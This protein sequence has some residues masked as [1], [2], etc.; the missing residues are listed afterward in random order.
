MEKDIK[1]L[2]VVKNMR[3][4][5]G[6]ASFIMNYYRELVKIKNVHIDFLVVSD[7][8]SIYYDEIRKNSNI[9]FMPSIR[10]P[11][12]VLRFLKN[13]FKLNKYNILHSNVFNSNV[14]I[15]YYAKK[16]KVPIRILHSHASQ[17]GDSLIKIIRN[18]VFL[19]A[20]LN[21]SNIFFACS[22][23]AGESIFKK[24]KYYCINNA[25]D[26]PMFYYNK[27]TRQQIR[28][29]LNVS[30]HT[31]V[32]GVVG[33]VT[34]QKNPDFIIEIAKRLKAKNFDFKIIWI[35]SG[36][37]SDYIDKRIANENLSNEIKML[38]SLN[39]SHLYY[40]AFDVFLMPSF[41]EGLPIAGV[42]A[43]VNGLQCILSSQI[44]DEV[45]ITNNCNLIDIDN[46]DK[47]CQRINALKPRSK[48]P[49]LNTA[50]FSNYD[51]NQN[52]NKLYELYKSAISSKDR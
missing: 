18:K 24:K 20:N 25:I 44:S 51:I 14:P 7:A 3:V 15:V 46:V 33:R 21:Y 50:L 35:G 12:K 37:L 49:R 4:A 10:R 29:K 8:G 34:R 32:L 16:Y 26:L 39:D 2:F 31:L 9:Y 1:I 42:E 45:K 11:I 19:I 6:V 23:I 30:D 22:R 27:H 13:L 47:W 28:K 17:N 48:T 5:S 36:D 41:Y 38:G 43:Q 52:A 40:S